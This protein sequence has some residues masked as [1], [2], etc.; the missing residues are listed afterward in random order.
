MNK[1]VIAAAAAALFLPAGAIAADGAFAADKNLSYTYGQFG[2]SDRDF[3]GPSADGFDIEGSYEVTDMVF[4]FGSYSDLSGDFDS[5][6]LTFGAGAAIGLTDTVDGYGKV[7][8]IDSEIGPVD[9]SGLGLEF[10]VRSMIADKIELF[11][12]LQYVDIY[13]DTDTILELGGRYW[14]QDNLGFSVSYQD[15]DFTGSG[16][17]LAARY[18]F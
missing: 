17:T 12:D 13:D 6:A 5:S 18:G 1:N 11:G 3:D 9:D 14:M 16:I 8:F 7:A 2:Y 10:G 4:V 15:G